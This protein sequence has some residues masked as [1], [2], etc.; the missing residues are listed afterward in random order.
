[1]KAMPW[2]IA[3]WT[4]FLARIRQ[5]AA[6]AKFRVKCGRSAAWARL[7]SW[8]SNSQGSV[9]GVYR[10]QQDRHQVS[11]PASRLRRGL[12][13]THELVERQIGDNA[14][15]R[16]GIHYDLIGTSEQPF[17]GFQIHALTS[18]LGRL[19]VFV[20]DLEKTGRRALGLGDSLLAIGFGVLGDLRGT[21]VRLRNN[22]VWR[23]SVPRSAPARGRSGQPA[24]RGRS[25]SPASVDRPFVTAPALSECQS[26]T[27]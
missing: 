8:I 15:R 9:S 13:P 1:M 2:I 11:S 16:S 23:R 18:D 26:R 19:L 17:H 3:C 24:R 12:R 25:R 7:P 6:Q 4:A 20:V 14:T 21:A 10:A 27:Y 5:T 22:L